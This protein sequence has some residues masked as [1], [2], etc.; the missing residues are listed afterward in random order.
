ML[1]NVKANILEYKIT[2]TP[3]KHIINIL[4]SIVHKKLKIEIGDKNINPHFNDCH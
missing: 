4:F 1:N 2:L 3:I